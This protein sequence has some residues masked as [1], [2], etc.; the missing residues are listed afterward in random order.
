[1][2]GERLGRDE[3]RLFYEVHP[4]NAWGIGYGT[5]ALVLMLCAA[6]FGIRRRMLDFAPRYKFGT[7]HAWLH[8]HIYAGL[9]SLLL[10]WMHAGLLPPTGQ[11]T[12]L[13]WALTTWTVFSGLVGLGLLR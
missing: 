12:T 13:L 2:E 8:L 5:A 11:L 10:M 9:L 7:S 6:G 3:H 1:M 4:G